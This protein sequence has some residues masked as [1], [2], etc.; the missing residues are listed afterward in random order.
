VDEMLDP[1]GG[2]RPAWR[3]FVAQFARTA[4]DERSRRFARGD[5]YLRDAGVFFRRYGATGS[6]ER[7]WPLAHVPVLIEATEWRAV[8]AGLVQRAELL[9]AVAADLYGPNRLVAEGH[10]PASLVAASREWLRPLVGLTPR[11][12]RFLHFSPLSSGAAPTARGGCSATAP[13]PVRRGLRAGEPRGDLAHLRRP[14]R[15]RPGGAARGFFRTFRDALQRLS[16]P[17]ERVAIL[18]PGPLNDT[19]FEHAYIARYLGFTLLEGEDLTVEDGRVMVRTVAGLEP[20]SVLWRRLDA[21]YAD[22]LELDAGSRIGAPGLVGAVRRGSVTLV[23]ALGSGVLETRALL[24]FL[25]RIAEV[26]LGEP[27]KIPNIAT[28]VVWDS[29]GARARA[30]RD[31]PHGDRLGL[32]HP[33]AL[34]CLRAHRAWRPVPRPRPRKRGVLAGGRGRAAR[35]PGGGDPFDHARL[36]G[37]RAR[38]AAHEPARLSRAHARGLGGDARRLRSHRAHPGPHGDRHAAR[39]LGGGRLGRQRGARGARHH[40]GG[41]RRRTFSRAKAAA[42]PTRAADNLFWLGRYVERAEGA[43]RLCGRSTSASRR[44]A[45]A[46]RRWCSTSRPS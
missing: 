9:E 34:R 35:R 2:V 5:Q 7:A 10:L 19:Y 28:L 26:L 46:R 41:P 21:S 12:G 13:G 24:A 29:G 22:P 36:G 17:G 6:T 32:L 38:A 23:N 14:L 11:G 18:S 42:L 43:M 16:E 44:R 20:V 4:P 39:R 3:Q 27:L 25:P 40:A 37:R 31:R 30:R 45:T 8:A 33:D 1:R 15:R